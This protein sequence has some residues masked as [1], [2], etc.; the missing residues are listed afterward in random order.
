MEHNVNICSHSCRG[1]SGHNIPSYPHAHRQRRTM[2]A[3]SRLALVLPGLLC[4]DTEFNCRVAMDENLVLTASTLDL[5][6]WI[7]VDKNVRPRMC[8]VGTFK[9][10]IDCF[11]DNNILKTDMAEAAIA[12]FEHKMFNMLKAQTEER[13]RKKQR[14]TYDE[15]EKTVIEKNHEIMLLNVRLRRMKM[16]AS[17]ATDKLL[18]AED[19]AGQAEREAHE[20]MHSLMIADRHVPSEQERCP[21]C[22]FSIYPCDRW[23][24]ACGHSLHPRC[25]K[26][27]I[28]NSMTRCPQCRASLL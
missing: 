21:I 18:A 4:G 26:Q 17:K 14:I 28:M 24:S 20:A 8:T 10:I 22:T 9:E 1:S 2:A 3:T 11:V 15:L 19:R 23:E 25:K 16:L 13:S 12:I 5:M 6:N 27:M 7:G